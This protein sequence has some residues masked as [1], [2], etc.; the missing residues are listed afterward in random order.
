MTATSQDRNRDHLNQLFR[1]P[2]EQW[3]A[4]VSTWGKRQ[5]MTPLVYEAFRSA[6]RQAYLYASG[7]VRPGPV[8]TYTL[9]SAHELGV[10]VDWVPLVG[11]KQC[12]D[13]AL[14]DAVYAAV[15]PGDYGLETLSFERPHVQIK[16]VNGPNFNVSSSV[17]GQTHGLRPNVIVG[18]RW[19]LAA[20]ATDSRRVF[21]RGLD[22]TN[23]V[24]AAPSVVYGGQVITRLN[25]GQL[26][27]G[28]LIQTVYDDGAVQFDRAR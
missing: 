13:T 17:W 6:E 8:I 15:P 4:K 5:N 14:Y 26:Q 27:I 28:P 23:V 24:M 16:G 3:L 19:P 1:T 10:A 2:L 11:G 12:W 18:S 20:P 22:G 7:R 25:S 21:L 9:D